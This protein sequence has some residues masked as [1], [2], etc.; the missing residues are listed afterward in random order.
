MKGLPDIKFIIF[1]WHCWFFFSSSTSPSPKL[2]LYLFISLKYH[3]RKGRKMMRDIFLSLLFFSTSCI[4]WNFF[5]FLLSPLPLPYWFHFAS[6]RVFCFF[7][8][9]LLVSLSYPPST[10]L[11]LLCWLYLFSIFPH[12][13][14]FQQYL[15]FSF[16]LLILSRLF[17]FYF[18]RFCYFQF[19]SSS[20]AFYSY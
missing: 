20:I 7:F 11:L 6:S 10:E 5:S 2:K 12:I 4:P 13:I 9:Y 17:S 3:D 19:F 18:I 14:R 8:R 16:L 15:L 1:T